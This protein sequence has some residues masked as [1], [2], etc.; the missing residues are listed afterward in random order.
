M[1]KQT[2]DTRYPMRKIKVNRPDYPEIKR[3]VDQDKR[4]IAD[5]LG[6]AEGAKIILLLPK[7]KTIRA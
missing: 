7:G 1:M 6:A 2:T 4:T 5:N 3:I